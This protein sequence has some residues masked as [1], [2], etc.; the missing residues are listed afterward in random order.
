MG[1]GYVTKVTPASKWNQRRSKPTSFAT[2]SQVN[3]LNARLDRLVERIRDMKQLQLMFME[4]DK[5]EIQDE[6]DEDE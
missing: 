1:R 4:L 3:A 5:S 2:K 6:M